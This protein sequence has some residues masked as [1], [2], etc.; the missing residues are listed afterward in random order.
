MK[1]KNKDLQQI[2]HRHRQEQSKFY[3][4]AHLSYIIDK[5]L[6]ESQDIDM[7]KDIN[8]KQIALKKGCNIVLDFGET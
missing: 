2:K 8:I 6:Q 5:T 7:T 4:N 1:K 3:Y